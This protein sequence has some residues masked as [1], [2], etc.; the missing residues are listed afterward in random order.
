MKPCAIHGSDFCMVCAAATSRWTYIKDWLCGAA[1]G[2][3]LL[4]IS[5]MI[6]WA[7]FIVIYDYAT[8]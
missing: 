2:A 4:F 1:L 8:R 5:S 3:G 6:Y 7:V